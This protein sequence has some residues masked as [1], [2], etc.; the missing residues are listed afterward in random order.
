MHPSGAPPIGPNTRG[1]VPLAMVIDDHPLFCEALSMTLRSALDVEHVVTCA[2]LAEG[3]ERLQ[4][5]PT[6]DVV[7][8]DLK[9]PDVD[10]IDGLIRLK[11]G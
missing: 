6:P 1:R 5:K 8:L 4:R 9:L 2:T 3:L 10:G 7:L 11:R